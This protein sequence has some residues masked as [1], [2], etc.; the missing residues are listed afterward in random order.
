MEFRLG[1]AGTGLIPC[2]STNWV[3]N[4][5]QFQTAWKFPRRHAR[6]RF[7]EES[8]TIR[9]GRSPQLLWPNYPVLIRKFACL[10]SFEP[11]LQGTHAFGRT[12][13]GPANC[14]RFSDFIAEVRVESVSE[15]FKGKAWHLSIT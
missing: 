9:D 15:I 6:I 7:V 1:A 10:K 14:H 13:E 4:R 5:R 3:V 8:G 11:N 2:N 12:L